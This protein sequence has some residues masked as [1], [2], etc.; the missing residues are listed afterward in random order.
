MAE[1]ALPVAADL[2]A[3]TLSLPMWPDLPHEDVDH[4]VRELEAALA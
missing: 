4:V 3:R 1:D 2:G